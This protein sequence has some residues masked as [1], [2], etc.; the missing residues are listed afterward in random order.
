MLGKN[1]SSKFYISSPR[2]SPTEVS[3]FLSKME[4]FTK[5]SKNRANFKKNFTFFRKNFKEI[6]RTLKD[7]GKL[8]QFGG[9]LRKIIKDFDEILDK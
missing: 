7:A 1:F 2:D 9:N 3:K 8:P 5:I 4:I 6:E